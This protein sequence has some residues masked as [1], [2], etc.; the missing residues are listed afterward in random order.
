[1][2]DTPPPVDKGPAKIAGSAFIVATFGLL[3][4]LLVGLALYYLIEVKEPFSS[5]RVWVALGGALYAGW[6]A[7]MIYSKNKATNA[8]G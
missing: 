1:M 4:V 8:R 3:A 2:S 6:R 7:W 5:P